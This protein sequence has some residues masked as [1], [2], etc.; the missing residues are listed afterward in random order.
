MG[1]LDK[2]DHVGRSYFFV[3]LF[4]LFQTTFAFACLDKDGRGNLLCAG[5][6]PLDE[7]GI[8]R[9]VLLGIDASAGTVPVN[10]DFAALGFKGEGMDHLDPKFLLAVNSEGV[11]AVYSFEIPRSVT[12]RRK[13]PPRLIDAENVK[14]RAG[15]R[16][17][18]DNFVKFGGKALRFSG[19]P[20]IG[21]PVVG[22]YFV[23]KQRQNLRDREGALLSEWVSMSFP[24]YNLFP[25][26]KN[27]LASDE[28]TAI[29][30]LRK[31]GADLLVR[32][33]P[34]SK[35]RGLFTPQSH[36]DSVYTSFREFLIDKRKKAAE[37]YF[38]KNGSSQFQIKYLGAEIAL[39]LVDLSSPEKLSEEVKKNIRERLGEDFLSHHRSSEGDLLPYSLV[40]FA[41][42]RG[43]VD[44]FNFLHPVE[45]SR[46]TQI[47]STVKLAKDL[48]ATAIPSGPLYGTIITGVIMGAELTGKLLVKKGLFP[49][50]LKRLESYGIL[51]GLTETR[52]IDFSDLGKI[53]FTPLKNSL[54]Y[55]D[56]PEQKINYLRDQMGTANQSH[57][58]NDILSLLAQGSEIASRLFMGEFG[59]E[60][61][62]PSLFTEWRN[63][64]SQRL[65][66]FMGEE[67]NRQIIAEKRWRKEHLALTLSTPKYREKLVQRLNRESSSSAPEEL[68]EINIAK[69]FFH[70]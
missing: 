47:K 21:A 57:S 10:E 4:I 60:T 34:K 64:A 43:P 32:Y 54:E 67:T 36:P 70:P 17:F 26:L 48:G 8:N 25:E 41:N 52:G 53:N 31:L 42:T 29:H 22:T 55:F 3:I 68:R 2:G 66:N 14:K 45:S 69:K 51:K 65:G 23:R 40:S 12:E 20:L 33:H 39:V 9:L 15:A 27:A 18:A 28:K 62:N 56:V 30:F 49:K 5:V 19:I 6:Y 59:K 1:T 35:F 7:Q 63:K 24:P 37:K 16:F 44:L 50:L 46:R 13:L 38:Q 61:E 58:L 11:S